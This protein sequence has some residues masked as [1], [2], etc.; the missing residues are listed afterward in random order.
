MT[1]EINISIRKKGPT[2][3]I[4]DMNPSCPVKEGDV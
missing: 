2:N 3:D 4:S 1:Q